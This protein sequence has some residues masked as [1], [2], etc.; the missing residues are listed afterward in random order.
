MT[1]FLPALFSATLLSAP[2]AP[3]ATFFAATV[4]GT[5]PVF[6]RPGSFAI[7]AAPVTD[8]TGA[9]VSYYTVGFTVPSADHYRIETT[10]AVLTPGLNGNDPT[11]TFLTLYLGLFFRPV[12]AYANVARLEMASPELSP[13]IERMLPVTLREIPAESLP[14]PEPV[15]ATPAAAS[16]PTAAT[17][18]MT[19]ASP[20]PP[21][22]P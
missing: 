6:D 18:E 15:S 5:S 19:P 1:R 20:A 13:R 7:G 3:A 9:G 16:V 8:P 2:L 11:D 17:P 10:A 21:A 22:T 12:L 14:A 4:D